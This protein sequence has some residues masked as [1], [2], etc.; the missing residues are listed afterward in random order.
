MPL[1]FFGCYDTGLILTD[2]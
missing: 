2:S 1:K